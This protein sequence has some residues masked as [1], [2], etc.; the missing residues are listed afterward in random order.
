MGGN[1]IPKTGGGVSL[2][3]NEVHYSVKDFGDYNVSC[4]FIELLWLK[5]ANPHQRN[6]AVCIAYHPLKE[7]TSLITE[8]VHEICCNIIVEI[9]ILGD[10]NIN[11]LY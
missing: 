8:R 9:Y 4:D 3:Q 6:L 10:F 1:S 2:C 5:I 7:F 11:Y